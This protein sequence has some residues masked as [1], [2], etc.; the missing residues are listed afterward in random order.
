MSAALPINS[1]T[2][3]FLISVSVVARERP[4]KFGRGDLRHPRALA[5]RIIFRPRITAQLSTPSLERDGW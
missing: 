5:R 3:G 4:W 1:L 2:P